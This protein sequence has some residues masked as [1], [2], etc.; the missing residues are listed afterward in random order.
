MLKFDLIRSQLVI[1]ERQTTSD[2]HNESQ[3]IAKPSKV[4]FD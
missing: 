2:L 3:I 1:K 4:I